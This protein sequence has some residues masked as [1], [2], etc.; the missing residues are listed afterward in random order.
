M[1][2]WT[3]DGGTIHIIWEEQETSTD[4]KIVDRRPGLCSSQRPKGKSGTEQT[5]MRRLFFRIK[6]RPRPAIVSSSKKDTGTGER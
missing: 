4:T 6:E 3:K 2:P 5:I 1:L